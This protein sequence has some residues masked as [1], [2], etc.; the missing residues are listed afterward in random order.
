MTLKATPSEVGRL[1]GNLKFVQ[2]T[3]RT[4]R[5]VY[6]KRSRISPVVEQAIDECLEIADKIFSFGVEER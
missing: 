6:G 3:I 5:K 1:A 4:D 2:E